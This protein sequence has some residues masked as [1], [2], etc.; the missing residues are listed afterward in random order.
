[1]RTNARTLVII[2]GTALLL[3]VLGGANA[4]RLGA[5]EKASQISPNDPTVRLYSLLDSKFN[6]KLDDFFLMADTVNDPKNPGQTQQHVLCVD[7]KKDRGFGKLNIHL[8]TVSQL[9][10]EQ[11]K[12]YSPKQIYD[13]AETDT[14]KFTKTD[15]G[16][17]GKVGDVY[18]E[19][20]PDGGGIATAPVTPEVQA[21]YERFVTQYVLPG[22][23]KKA[24]EGNG[25]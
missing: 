12:A 5:K 11:M 10:P 15:P 19:P 21:Q 2:V 4:G 16:P 17:F 22:L 24:A 13:F 14:A 1:M 20:S 9:T 8:R 25:S 23:E 18:L 3:L 6:G 7:Y